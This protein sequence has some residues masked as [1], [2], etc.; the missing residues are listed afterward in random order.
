MTWVAVISGVQEISL[1][2]PLRW[3]WNYYRYVLYPLR[4]RWLTIRRTALVK[5]ET[6]KLINR[7]SF[8]LDRRR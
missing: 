7:P 6:L 8:L 1:S 2:L 3:V 5:T 4:Q